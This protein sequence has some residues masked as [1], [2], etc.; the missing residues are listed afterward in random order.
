MPSTAGT[1]EEAGLV[2]TPED[3]TGAQHTPPASDTVLWVR[4]PP[5]LIRGGPG[6]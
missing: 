3:E 6:G 4:M 5:Q 1:T 2:T